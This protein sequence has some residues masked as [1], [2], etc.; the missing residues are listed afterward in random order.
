MTQSTNG[1]HIASGRQSAAPAVIVHADIGTDYSITEPVS[2]GYTIVDSATW[3][4]H[5]RDQR[6]GITSP[7]HVRPW[8]QAMYYKSPE[9][10]PNYLAAEIKSAAESGGVGWLMWNPQ[11][12]WSI[13]YQAVA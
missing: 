4:A 12:D 13:A 6:L 5:H 7:I 11:Q 2:L 3:D 1:A 9:Y 10:G 8:L